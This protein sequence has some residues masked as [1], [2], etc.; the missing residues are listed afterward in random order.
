MAQTLLQA[1]L[2]GIHTA[3]AQQL[4]VTIGTESSVLEIITGLSSLLIDG[5][6]P[7]FGAV[8]TVGGIMIAGAHGNDSW[9]EQGKKTVMGG[10]VGFCVTVGAFGILRMIMAFIYCPG[11]SFCQ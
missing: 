1:L 4:Q 10:V 5:V 11:A 8:M 9:A 2:L 6:V 3:S 7:I